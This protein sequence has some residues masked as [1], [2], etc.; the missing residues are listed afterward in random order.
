MTYGYIRVS[1]ADQNEARQVDALLEAG[2]MNENIFFD[3][4]SGKDFN[5][6]G[7]RRLKRKIKRGDLLIVQSLDRLGRNY[8]EIT[9]EWREIV[10]IKGADI[11]ILNMPVL[12]TTN[13]NNGLIGR[14]VVDIVLQI[15]SF[16]AENERKNI[17]ERQRQ[18]INA[19]K[20]R[21]VVFG[22]PR[23][24]LP[25][26]FSDYAKKALLGQ[27]SIRA[28]ATMCDLSRVT[29]WRALKSQNAA[30]LV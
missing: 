19:A 22:R 7:W 16:V 2:I 13:N 12:D 20:L 17:L 3:K 27:M 25:S 6:P 23:K 8:T 30:F 10:K 29:F 5:R 28:A 4:Q 1:S 14:F 18:G 9:E 15:L 21:G 26:S 24:P 11:R